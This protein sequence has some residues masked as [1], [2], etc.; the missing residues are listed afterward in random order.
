MYF[1]LNNIYQKYNFNSKK[2][3]VE[4][5]IKSFVQAFP[6]IEVLEHEMSKRKSAHESAHDALQPPRFVHMYDPLGETLT[7]SLEISFIV[8]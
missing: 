6:E 7:S 8:N 1:D 3:S 2:I 5:P 4:A